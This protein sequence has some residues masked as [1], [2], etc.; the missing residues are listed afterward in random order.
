ML[1]GA[2]LLCG[3]ASADSSH[4]FRYV[5]D[6]G[7]LVINH[8]IPP[9]LVK[10][11][12]EIITF[13][14]D[15]VKVVNPSRTKA[16]KEKESERKKLA[17]KFKQL[18]KR[19]ASIDDLEAAKRRRIESLNT[20]IAIVRSN[21]GSIENRI[22]NLMADAADQER[23]GK[24]VSEATLQNIET[25]KAELS[26][27]KSQLDIRLAEEQEIIDQFNEDVAIFQKG[28]ALIGATN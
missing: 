9:E 18:K 24:E 17:S 2:Y 19:Y 5:N 13:N 27:A 23:A 6:E 16:E 4:F 21:I 8:T 1:L 10:N 20:N 22:E 11:G 26:V 28:N 3:A 14:G 12:Y 25:A 15:V 7:V